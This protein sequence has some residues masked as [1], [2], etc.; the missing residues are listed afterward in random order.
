MEIKHQEHDIET[1]MNYFVQGFK[2]KPGES[3]TRHEWFYD[4]R[5]GKVVFKLY[6]ERDSR[7]TVNVTQ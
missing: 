2:M 6:V 5:K 3:I 7:I 1:V 4:S